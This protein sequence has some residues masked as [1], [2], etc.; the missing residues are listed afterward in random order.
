MGFGGDGIDNSAGAAT[1]DPS[2]D[3]VASTEFDGFYH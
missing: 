2:D 3:G 1:D